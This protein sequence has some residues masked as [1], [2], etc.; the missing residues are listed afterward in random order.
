MS[1]NANDELNKI[2]YDFKRE[3]KLYLNENYEELMNEE[4]ATI[5]N[6]GRL[7][8]MYEKKIESKMPKVKEIKLNRLDDYKVREKMEKYDGDIEEL[9][10][11]VRVEKYNEFKDKLRSVYV[12]ETI[13]ASCKF[14][15]TEFMELFSKLSDRSRYAV[16][17]LTHTTLDT[18]VKLSDVVHNDTII[19]TCL[20]SH[21]K[22][23]HDDR[24]KTLKHLIDNGIS[25]H[26]RNSNKEYPH[27]TIRCG[28]YSKT[29]KEKTLKFLVNYKRDDWL[30]KD[31]YIII[32]KNIDE[33]CKDYIIKES[34]NDISK[35][36]VKW[37]SDM[38]YYTEV[39]DEE[40]NMIAN[41]IYL[42]SLT[43]IFKYDPLMNAK[44]I[45]FTLKN[46]YSLSQLLKY[47]YYMDDISIRYNKLIE[48]MTYIIDITM[49][50]MIKSLIELQNDKILGNKI[51]LD[52]P[53]KMC[54][55]LYSHSNVYTEFI[56]KKE[57]IID[58]QKKHTGIDACAIYRTLIRK[59]ICI[60]MNYV[61]NTDKIKY[62][63]KL[64][65]ILMIEDLR[66]IMETLKIKEFNLVLTLPEIKK[67]EKKEKIK[68]YEL[69][70]N[71]K[72]DTDEYNYNNLIN[73]INNCNNNSTYI[74]INYILTLLNNPKILYSDYDIFNRA[75][76]Y[77]ETY[78]DKR[79]INNIINYIYTTNIYED[80]VESLCKAEMLLRKRLNL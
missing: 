79:I 76:E 3:M 72:I 62:L 56:E 19:H 74:I 34:Y 46:I 39:T 71:T 41:K 68:L 48:K 51:N 66:N 69:L 54:A 29:D 60:F 15:K 31:M 57:H 21:E 64:S 14:G 2:L 30:L 43:N 16:K 4:N 55:E 47:K 77:I 75:I 9:M 45:D 26:I 1:S 27:E 49:M 78:Y 37:K 80:Y 67:I 36:L 42:T 23:N 58:N 5:V 50:K 12:N 25:R 52:E 38:E 59:C 73:S 40:I 20:Y 61:D 44:C 18:K 11:T 6:I 65:N 32:S 70:I 53:I 17:F 24:I 33:F 8:D 10:D 22:T 35:Y 7:I 63:N 28:K 13:M